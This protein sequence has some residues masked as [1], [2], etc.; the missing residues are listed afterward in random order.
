MTG[1]EPAVREPK[2]PWARRARL[3]ALP[4]AAAVL[5]AGSAILRLAWN[6]G[7][8]RTPGALPRFEAASFREGF[9]AA[10]G[11]VRVVALLSPT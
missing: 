7:D 2:G 9:N 10:R 4:L 6:G 11:T 3:L 1:A 5:V 8:T